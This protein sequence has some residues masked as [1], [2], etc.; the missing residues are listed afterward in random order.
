MLWIFVILSAPGKA[1]QSK[2]VASISQM[3][4]GYSETYKKA[5]LELDLWG[6]DK[7]KVLDKEKQ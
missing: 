1:N 6:Y 4:D 3:G 5:I 7:C 2:N